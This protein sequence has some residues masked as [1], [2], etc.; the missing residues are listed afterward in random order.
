[1]VSYLK[2]LVLWG[3]LSPV[4]KISFD[5]CCRHYRPSGSTNLVRVSGQ[6]QDGCLPCPRGRYGSTVGLKTHSCSGACPIGTYSDK[7]GLES[8]TDCQKCPPGTYG[9]Y[10]GLTTA[11]CSG[12]CPAG[13]YS[14][15]PGSSSC[16]KCP[17]H[18]HG[19][20]C[21]KDVNA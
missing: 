2:S 12:V 13:T 9:L 10:S 17:L 11:K 16:K 20:Q 1:M 18:Y 4:F 15:E 3:R 6:R 14:D 19:W 5:E 8:I 21:S 7:V